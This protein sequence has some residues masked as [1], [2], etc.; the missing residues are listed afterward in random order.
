MEA[1]RQKLHA[2]TGI[3][4]AGCETAIGQMATDQWRGSSL[5]KALEAARQAMD[6]VCAAAIE[7]HC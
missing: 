6:T 7:P 1:V 3:A 4:A 2:A 5:Q